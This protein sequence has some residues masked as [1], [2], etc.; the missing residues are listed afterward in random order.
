MTFK[1]SAIM[2]PSIVVFNPE[3]R[4][5]S[6]PKEGASRTSYNG[7]PFRLQTSS[8]ENDHFGTQNDGEKKI[9][10]NEG[11]EAIM[12]LRQLF[13]IPSLP[14][15]VPHDWTFFL[16][17]FQYNKSIRL[18]EKDPIQIPISESSYDRGGG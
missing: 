2:M 18:V 7:H 8:V 6:W 9:I 13:Q 17:F 12:V 3:E 11:I 5:A 15:K 16:Y 1:D 14:P 4:G 10:K